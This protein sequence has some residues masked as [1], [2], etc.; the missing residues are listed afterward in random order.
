[1]NAFRVLFCDLRTDQLLDALPVHGLTLDDWIGKAGTLGGAI[2]VP[3]ASLAARVRRAVVPG[4]TAVWVMHGRQVWW[5]GILWTATVQSD[6]RGTLTMPIQA[7]TFDSYLDHRRVFATIKHTKADQYEIVR[8]LL[9]YVQST[10]GGDIGIE[11][12][13]T[14]SGVVRDHVVSRYDVAPVRDVL[15]QLAAAESGFEWRIASQLDADGRRVK[16]LVLG[17]PVIRSGASEIVL[18]HP[19]SVI[20]YSWPIDATTLANTWQSRGATDNT[21]QA[22]ESTP[23]LS[24][25]LEPTADELAGWPRLDG[26]SDYSTIARLADL[27]ARARADLARARTPRVIP[28]ITVRLTPD[29]TPALLGATVRLRIRDLWHPNGLD[30]RY[31]VVGMAVTPPERGAAESARLYLEI[32]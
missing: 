20:S 8:A 22:A 14:A 11:Y 29:I 26:A 21:N 4:R 9:A 32:P 28:E 3:N 17:Q 7:G 24:R 25:L 6:D 15:D 23:L 27:D 19:G 18:T 2:P 1:M 13:V 30:V 5:G 12:D 10:T 16:R 31:R